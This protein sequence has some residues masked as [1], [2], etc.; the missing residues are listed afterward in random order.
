MNFSAL[1]MTALGLL[2]DTNLSQMLTVNHTDI[3]RGDTCGRT[4]LMWAANRGHAEAVQTLLDWKADISLASCSGETAL[5]HAVIGR[6]IECVKRLLEAGADVHARDCNGYSV[7]HLIAINSTPLDPGLALVR[8]CLD[9]GAPVNAFDNSGH[10][11]LH[12]AAFCGNVDQTEVLL[13]KDADINATDN[14][15]GTPLDTAIAYSSVGIVRLLQKHGALL[16][17]TRRTSVAP[18]ALQLVAANGSVPLM[19]ELTRWNTQTEPPHLSIAAIQSAWEA[20]EVVRQEQYVG[21][22]ATRED[23]RPAFTAFM[24]SLSPPP[25]EELSEHELE[26]GVDPKH[27][28]PVRQDNKAGRIE[29]GGPGATPHLRD[30]T[31]RVPRSHPQRTETTSDAH[32]D[33]IFV[34]AHENHSARE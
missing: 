6:S 1:H 8:I 11:A 23:E 28:N 34:D 15:R 10:T 5:H 9:H 32:D 14:L 27:N 24:A 7:L 33:D 18:N 30:R 19:E 16:D 21:Q 31:P 13:E 29:T 22:T 2:E 4:P 25:I 26:S 12:W 3:N 17:Y 20:F